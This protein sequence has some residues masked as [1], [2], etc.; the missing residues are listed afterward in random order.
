MS[1]IEL[2]MD[3]GTNDNLIIYVHTTVVDVIGAE[4][5]VRNYKNLTDESHIV[6]KK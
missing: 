3:L 6:G 4:F 5:E 1:L 2:V